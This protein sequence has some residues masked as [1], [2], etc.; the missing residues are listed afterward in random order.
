MVCGLQINNMF[1]S[2]YRSVPFSLQARSAPRSLKWLRPQPQQPWPPAGADGGDRSGAASANIW[3][4][5][6][7][8]ERPS[9]ST[10]CTSNFCKA[11]AFSNYCTMFPVPSLGYFII[12][13]GVWIYQGLTKK[14][15]RFGIGCWGDGLLVNIVD[16]CVLNSGLQE[17]PPAD[18]KALVSREEAKIRVALS[19]FCP[20]EVR[21]KWVKEH[22][23]WPWQTS[24]LAIENIL[25]SA[26]CVWFTWSH[27][28]LLNWPFK[29]ISSVCMK[30]H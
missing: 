15:S 9:D 1:L 18:V 30:R 25:P 16:Y 29:P 3:V 23:A 11:S 2:R 17:K 24:I 7:P 28:I 4:G 20:D 5:L 26:E 21:Q 19:L 22:E 8:A 13:L 10:S 27:V 14:H 6:S 12:K